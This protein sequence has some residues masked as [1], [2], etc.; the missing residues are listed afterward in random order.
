MPHAS[1]LDQEEL[2]SCGQPC[3]LLEPGRFPCVVSGETEAGQAQEVQTHRIDRA[4]GE[5]QWVKTVGAGR[6]AKTTS[7]QG[8]RLELCWWPVNIGTAC[9]L[10]SGLN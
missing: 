5:L 9:L 6:A 8:V 7:H 4:V 2:L 10:S 1:S 3:P